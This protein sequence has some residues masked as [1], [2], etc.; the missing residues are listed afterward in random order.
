MAAREA[1]GQQVRERV[2]QTSPT[3]SRPPSS[4]PPPARGQRPRREP[5]GRR[6]G[7]PPG[8][9]G[10]PRARVP[11]AAVAISIPVKP[12]QGVHCQQ[13]VPGEEPQPQRPQ[14]TEIPP[15]KPV[16]TAEPW[17]RL[18]GPAG[19][20]L[21]RAERPP[22]V[23]PGGCGPRVQA[24]AALCP[25]ASH[26]AQ[27][28]TQSLVADRLRVARRLGPVMNLAQATGQAVAA[29]VA[30]ARRSVP[31]PPVAHLD[32]PGWRAGPH[33]AWLWTAGTAA[34]TGVGRRVARR[35]Q[36]AQARWGER[37]WGGWI[38]DRGSG[39]TG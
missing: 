33:R 38:T 20:Q 13:P 35:G 14:V 36:G 17:H 29:P 37:L 10:P 34:G 21:P 5:S 39:Y 1:M 26:R 3:S 31:E 23:P 27:R 8:H 11:V 6:P 7:G 30:A 19:G 9:A 24:I 28:T 16:V 22:G 4:A 18:G 25:G 12:R 2:Q 15:A 32:E